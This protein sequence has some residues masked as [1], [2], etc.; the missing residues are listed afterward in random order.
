MKEQIMIFLDLLDIKMSL[1]GVEKMEWIIEVAPEI[2]FVIITRHSC[3]LYSGVVWPTP[4]IKNTKID[5]T[6]T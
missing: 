2:H 1:Q 4:F 5:L 6:Q 3:G